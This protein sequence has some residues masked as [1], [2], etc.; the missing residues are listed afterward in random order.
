M[1][2]QLSPPPSEPANNAF[3]RFRASGRIDRSTVLESISIR[4][5]SRKRQRPSQRASV[6]D[7]LGKL[8]LLADERQL[9]AQPGFERGDDGTRSLLANGATFLGEA[10]ADVLLDSIEQRDALQR[11]VSD[12]RGF[13][14]GAVVETAAHM[15]PAACEADLALLS[16]RPVPGVAVDLENALEAGEMRDRLRG[17]SVGSV[18]IGDSRRVCSAPR[19]VVSG[20]S[21]ELPG[22]RPAPAGIEHRRRRL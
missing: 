13:G 17:R 6:A 11:F 8:A 15:R 19:A 9:G 10:L 21:P 2:A 16:Q 20:I 14:D 3:L 7:R 18:D 1:T 5:S 22:L 4:P 12:R